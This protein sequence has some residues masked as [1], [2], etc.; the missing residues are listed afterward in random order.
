M[1]NAIPNKI[2]VS[3]VLASVICAGNL[4]RGEVFS[5]E[6]IPLPEHP[7][8]DFQRKQWLNLNGPWQ[9]RFDENDIGQREKW[10]NANTSFPDTIMVPFPWGSKLSGIEDKADIGWYARSITVPES[11]PG[12]RVFL[13]IGASDWH[14]TAWLDGNLLGDYQGGYTPFEFDLTP[15]VKKGATH[16]LVLRVD[17]TPH[18]FK[19]EG[20]QGYGRAAGIWQTV[21]LEARP[22]VALETVHFTPDVDAGKV[23]V[24][25]TL[26]KP[27]PADMKLE[28]LFKSNDLANP[29][30]VRTVRK[31]AR[32]VRFDVAIGSPRLWSLEDPYLYEVEAVLR[33]PGAEDRV[34]TYFGMRKISVVNLPGTDFAYIALNDKPVYL[35]LALDQAYHP[36]GYY[37]FPSDDFMR[38]EILRSRRIGLNGQRIHIKVEVPR[39]LY[40]ADRL[41]VLI[42]ADVPN[43]WGPPDAKMRQETETA[44]RGMIRRDYNHPSIF[45]WVNFN[46]TW[47]LRTGKQGYTAE[48]QEWVA[49]IYELTRKLDATR[50]VEDNSPCNNDHV[51]TDI[52]S[53]HAYL[54]G[55]GWRER[56]GQITRDTYPG[57]K[58]N[59][60]GGRTQG[61]QPL[62]NSECGNVWGYQGSAGDVDWSWDYH[63]MMNEFRRH[64]EICGWLY[65]EHHDVINE[66]NGYYKYDRSEKYTGLSDVV[67]GMSLN[68]LHGQFYVASERELCRNVKPGE[69]VE[70]PLYASFMTDKPV[71]ENLTLK[72]ELSGWDTL[73]RHE[74]YS[75]YERDISYSPWMNKELRPLSVTMPDK[76]ALAVLSLILEDESGNILHRNFTTY[77]AAEGQSPRLETITSGSEKIKVVRFAPD[78]FKKAEWSLKQ[79]DVL[80][81]LKVNGAGAGYFEYSVPWPADLKVKDVAEANFRVEVSAKQL[82]GKDKEGARKQEG[83]FMRGK[84]TH[85]PSSNPNSYPM[86]DETRFPSAVRVNVAGRTVGPF[87]LE[88]DPADH[89]GILSWHSQKRDRK[90]REAGSYGYLINAHIPKS[91]LQDAAAK[92]EILLRLE[93]DDALPGGLAIYG[94]RF[95]RYP[96]DPTI[97][98]VLK[99]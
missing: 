49:S 69:N 47:G 18:K 46:E 89:R 79:W 26:D 38:D 23:S 66:W 78:S 17:D 54:P 86:T 91:V 11:W 9:F 22:G 62:L 27:A 25:A 96:L 5:S 80:E 28:L 33:G 73:G 76:P 32:E 45:S 60:I 1:R 50:L 48:T 70:V 65:T 34:A 82:F 19:L 93:V 6:N 98:F 52:N 88:D 20:K 14:T 85:D 95:G 81:G 41:G 13:V 83:N 12:Q 77:L 92:K 72:A 39:K 42:M 24:E 30:V 2:C 90:L 68:D 53:W 7:R 36:D 67:E 71:S 51:A 8:P 10:F 63:I 55:Y 56:L 58:W 94:E 15:H 59:Y 74:V 61:S 99:K 97:A 37:T 4:A 84:G 43:S 57:S 29:N 31:G 16:R 35:Q 75:K 87:D 44:L 64:P 21:Y 3:L 40:W